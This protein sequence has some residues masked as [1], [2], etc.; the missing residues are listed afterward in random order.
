MI[1]KW[2]NELHVNF[3]VDQAVEDFRE[4]TRWDPD[5]DPDSTIYHVV[6]ENFFIKGEEYLD[7]SAGIELAANAVRKALGGIQMKMDLSELD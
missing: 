2:V 6:N 3:D 7:I 1:I 5:A 4:I